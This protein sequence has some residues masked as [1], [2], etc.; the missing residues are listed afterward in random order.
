LRDLVERAAVIRQDGGASGELRPTLYRHVDIG[1]GDLDGGTATAIFLGG[2]QLSAAAAE[3]LEGEIS[4][5]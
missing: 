2:N 1:G 5:V 4:G 3:W